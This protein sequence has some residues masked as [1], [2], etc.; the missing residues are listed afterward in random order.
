MKG[1]F[2]KDIVLLSQFGFCRLKN[3]YV[4]T[5]WTNPL[6]KSVGA[7]VISSYA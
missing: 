5:L 4:L 6:K 2:G 3:R 1:G 7:T